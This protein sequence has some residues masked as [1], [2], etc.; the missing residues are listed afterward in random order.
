MIL[1]VS[2][3]VQQCISEF[4][5]EEMVLS[6]CAHAVPRDD[7]LGQPLEGRLVT[8]HQEVMWSTIVIEEPYG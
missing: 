1:V 6:A 8:H 5:V 2:T 3:F 7:P 4:V